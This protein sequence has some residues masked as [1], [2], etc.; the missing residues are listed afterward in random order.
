MYKLLLRS[1]RL[2]KASSRCPLLIVIKVWPFIKSFHGPTL[3]GAEGADVSVF[4]IYAIVSKNSLSFVIYTLYTV[5]WKL[6]KHGG[7]TRDLQTWEYD[8]DGGSSWWSLG[9]G[10]GAI[11]SLMPPTASCQMC[12]TLTPVS[13]STPD[14]FLL[15]LLIITIIIIIILSCIGCLTMLTML[16]IG[17]IETRSSDIF[18]FLYFCPS[19]LYH[20]IS[21][22]IILVIDVLW[23]TFVFL[24]FFSLHH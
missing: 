4:S 8:V 9:R 22:Q 11:P 17:H 7:W 23:M 16:E 20:L 18:V 5:V 13:W 12:L 19:V 6:S 10:H 24:S 2:R 14:T 3:L 21:S 15:L 1:K